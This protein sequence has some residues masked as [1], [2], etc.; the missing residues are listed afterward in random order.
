MTNSTTPSQTA[1]DT[2]QEQSDL[3]LYRLLGL[4]GLSGQFRKQLVQCF[5]QF[6]YRYS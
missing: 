6:G 3:G 5:V 4:Y 2:A 1:P